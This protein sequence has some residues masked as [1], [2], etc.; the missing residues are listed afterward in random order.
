MLRLARLRDNLLLQ[1]SKALISLNLILLFGFDE[2]SLLLLSLLP[3]GHG[4]DR[5]GFGQVNDIDFSWI[6]EKFETG[7]FLES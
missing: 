6:G 3:V 5:S 4:D 7:V 1:G 2:V